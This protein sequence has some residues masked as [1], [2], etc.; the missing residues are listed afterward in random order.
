[1][2]IEDAKPASGSLAFTTTGTGY[3]GFTLSG[4]PTGGGN[5]NTQTLHAG[6]YTVKEATQLGW[7]LTGIGGSTDTSTPYACVTTGSGGSTGSGSLETQTATISL[8]IGDTVACT[9]ENTGDG[10]TRTQG[11]WATHPQLAQIAW[12]GG[13]EYGHTFPGVTATPGIADRLICGQTVTSSLSAA[14]NQLM[15]GFWSAIPSTSTNKKRSALGQNRMQLLQQL[16]AAELNASAFGSV[17]AGG[18][19]AFAQWETALCGTNSTAVNTARQQAASFN[20]AGDSSVFTPGA[21][22]DSKTARLWADLKFWDV[23]N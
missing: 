4:N 23:F 17:P 7:A 1:V 15:G 20:T 12:D 14:A 22:A 10:A 21:S 2:I 5:T 9:F 8:E 19:G 3:N 18:T 16:L 6:T 13:A 11:F